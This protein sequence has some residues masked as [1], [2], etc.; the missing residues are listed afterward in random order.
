M[1]RFLLVAVAVLVL[2][3]G[4]AQ[5]PI[6]RLPK[7]AEEARVS[8]PLC[9]AVVFPD[10]DWQIVHTVD[11]QAADGFSGTLI[12]VTV[13][14]GDTIHCALLTVEGVTLFEAS[15]TGDWH[16]V[17]ERAVVPFNRPGFAQGLLA[18]VRTIFQ[19][20][21]SRDVRYG[22]TVD[23]DD[24]CRYLFDDG[25]VTDIVLPTHGVRTIAV[26]G[27][28]QVLTTTVSVSQVEG[29]YPADMLE[30]HSLRGNGYE[31]HM[32]LVDAVRLR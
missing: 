7:L 25:A 26:Y 14:A 27:A 23:G 15:S 18:D 16:V 32:H 11:F 12:G 6:V 1:N 9:G 8:A 31:L 28:D 2:T 30:L 24:V 20:P 17:V 22:R 5:R 29:G 10:G 13:L 3:S 19:V 21:S 4:C